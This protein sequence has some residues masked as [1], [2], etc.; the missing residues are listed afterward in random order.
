[1]VEYTWPEIPKIPVEFKPCDGG[2]NADTTADLGILGEWALG[3]MQMDMAAFK[4]I[5]P[6]EMK[7]LKDEVQY[8]FNKLILKF[9]AVALVKRG[10]GYGPLVTLYEYAQKELGRR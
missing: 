1:M 5:T 8:A 6:E 4:E 2:M 10:E 7:E 9:A 3:N